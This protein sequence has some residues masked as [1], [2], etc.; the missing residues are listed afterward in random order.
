[1]YQLIWS[2]VMETKY[3]LHNLFCNLEQQR[4]REKLNNENEGLKPG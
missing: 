2:Q 4:G 3:S 1:M